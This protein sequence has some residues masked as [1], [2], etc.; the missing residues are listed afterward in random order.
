MLRNGFVYV[1]NEWSLMLGEKNEGYFF[2]NSSIFFLFR[3]VAC[4]SLRSIFKQFVYLIK[5]TMQ[6]YSR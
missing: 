2:D 6:Q 1:I 4:I 3:D 5:H